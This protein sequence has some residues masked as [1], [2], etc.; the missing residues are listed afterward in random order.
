M[1]KPMHRKTVC[2]FVCGWQKYPT[3]HVVHLVTCA[4]GR[5]RSRNLR[6]SCSSW[7]HDECP[8]PLYMCS[9]AAVQPARGSSAHAG[10]GA[11]TAGWAVHSS[12]L[13][14]WQAGEVPARPLLPLLLVL[15][16]QMMVRGCAILASESRQRMQHTAV[17]YGAHPAPVAL[18]GFGSQQW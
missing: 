6:R 13:T 15:V 3:K 9:S 18:H 12:Q 4:S 10:A 14:A 11:H 7:A 8:I 17:Q 2:S 5:T 16:V 1:Q